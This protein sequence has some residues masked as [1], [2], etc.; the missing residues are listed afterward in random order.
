LPHQDLPPEISK[1]DIAFDFNAL[2]KVQL[3]QLGERTPLDEMEER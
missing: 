2:L 1:D 3:K